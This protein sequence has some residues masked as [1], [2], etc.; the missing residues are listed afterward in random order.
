MGPTELGSEMASLFWLLLLS[1]NA[2]L[3]LHAAPEKLQPWTTTLRDR[4]PA[5]AFA[6][7]YKVGGKRLVFVGAQHANRADS[8]TFKLIR[9]AYDRFAFDTVIAEGFATSRGA[10]PPSLFKYAAE[11]GPRPDGFVEGGETVPTVIGAEQ[12]KAAL[13]GGEA[14]DLAIKTRLLTKGFSGADVLGF[15]V[16]RNIPQWIG[17]RKI[18]NAGD[19]RLPA[20]VTEALATNREKLQMLPSILPG[21]ADWAAWYQVQNLRPIGAS[22]VTEEVGPLADGKFGTNRI[23]Y[24]ISRERDAHLHD[25]IITHLNAGEN[26]LVVFGA[27]HLMIH[28]PA[29]DAVLGRPCYVGAD[30]VRGATACR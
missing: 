1:S 30:L 12:Q 2:A 18:V 25:Q 8:L 9:Q 28:E 5:E 13:W 14:D 4:Q 16:L 20:L 27:S 6:A 24:A 7:V 21:F 11:A 10:N 22:F 15:Y 17:E 29:L 19:P 26:V 23:A 3:P